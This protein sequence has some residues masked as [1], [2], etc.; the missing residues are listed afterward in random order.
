VSEEVL[1]SRPLTGGSMDPNVRADIVYFT[2]KN[3]G[4]VFSTSS[5]AWCGSLLE[6]DCVNN[7][8]R[9]TANVLRRFSADEPL[10]PLESERDDGAA[11]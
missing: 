9:I 4:A 11:E 1:A 7:V 3:G 2:T 10:P 6:N 5:I 8:S